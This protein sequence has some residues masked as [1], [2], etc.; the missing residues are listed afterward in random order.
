MSLD[1]AFAADAQAMIT[2]RKWLPDREPQ[3]LPALAIDLTCAKY[4]EI[5][6]V[7]HALIRF[8]GFASNLPA[9][10]TTGFVNG[11]E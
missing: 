1:C 11:E 9:P 2:D 8:A 5:V 6:G 4:R 7:E 3:M 10:I